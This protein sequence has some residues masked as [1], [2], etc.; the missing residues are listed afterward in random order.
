[1]FRG[2]DPVKREA[3]YRPLGGGVEFGERAADAV[4]RELYEEI[5]ATVTSARLLGTV[6]NIFRYTGEP[7]HEIVFLYEVELAGRELYDCERIE[8]AQDN[9]EPLDCRWMP[10][11]AFADGGPPLYPDGLLELLNGASP[12]P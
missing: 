3:F 4:R 8:H 7:G 6:E 9:D 2:F 11:S 10:L 5:G 12:A 1:M